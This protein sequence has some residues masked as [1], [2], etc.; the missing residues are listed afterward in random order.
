MSQVPGTEEEIY[1]EADAR[2]ER[3]PRQP[4]EADSSRPPPRPRRA[5]STS[6]DNGP[7]RKGTF[8]QSMHCCWGRSHASSSAPSIRTDA[9]AV[10]PSGSVKPGAD[11][12]RKFKRGGAVADKVDPRENRKSSLRV[13]TGRKGRAAELSQRRSSLKKRDRTAER[14]AKAEAALERKTVQ[15][16]E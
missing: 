12:R 5:E 3:P 7:A 6:S 16:P 13:Q 8:F 9:A 2:P 4:R 11:P 14:V 1:R 10:S 15:I